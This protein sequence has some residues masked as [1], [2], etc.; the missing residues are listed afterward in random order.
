[1]IDSHKT[2]AY[3]ARLRKERDWTQLG[4]AD[5]LHVTHQAV[6]RWETGDSFP[7][8]G[9]LA[10]LAQVFKVHMETLLD[11]DQFSPTAATARDEVLVEL[12]EGHAER[13]AELVRTVPSD[14]ETVIEIGP[15]ARPSLM[16][17]IVKNMN[18]YHF[19]LE[20]V[21]SLAPFISQELLESIVAGLEEKLDASALEGLAPFL[22]RA[23]LDKLAERLP[24]KALSMSQ[25]VSLAPFLERSRLASLVGRMEAKQVR[26]EDVVE[27][28]PFLESQALNQ[29]LKLVPAGTMDVDMI[30]SLSPFLDRQMLEG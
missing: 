2:G 19:N 14:L 11:G 17:G 7:D 16:N 22:S 24:D 23:G 27:L 3:I 28:A 10:Q 5:M 29:L 18:G 9:T 26:P 6:S 4:L 1:M 12:A 25:I 20:Q 8:L 30:V 13:V 15:L 21:S